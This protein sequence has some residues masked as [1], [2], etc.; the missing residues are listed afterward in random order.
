MEVIIAFGANIGDREKTI[1]LALSA[2]EGRVGQI[3]LRSSL[4]ET[5]P[6][7]D[8]EC[9]VLEQDKFINGVVLVETSLQPEELLKTLQGIENELGR[10]RT[11]HWGPR[12]IDLDIIA[13]GDLVINSPELVVP[14]PEMAKRGFVLEPLAEILPEWAHPVSG[15]SVREL[16]QGL[17]G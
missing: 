17:I 16:R 1:G 6:L 4:Y 12:T 10:E 5:E 8:S 3:L 14:H 9:P 13:I 15:V 2:L 11:L 7:L